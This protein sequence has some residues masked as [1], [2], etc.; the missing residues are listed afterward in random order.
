MTVI[1]PITIT[2][3][4]IAGNIATFMGNSTALNLTSSSLFFMPMAEKASRGLFDDSMKFNTDIIEKYPYIL[5]YFTYETTSDD[6]CLRTAI[7]SIRDLDKFVR[8]IFDSVDVMSRNALS[9][10]AIIG[11]LL[12]SGRLREMK[13]RS[14]AN[15]IRAYSGASYSYD[16][17]MYTIL[18]RAE[19][20]W[21]KHG[22]GYFVAKTKT[23][24]PV[25]DVAN[26][27]CDRDVVHFMNL[28]RMSEDDNRY[29]A[30]RLVLEHEKAPRDYMRG[31]RRFVEWYTYIPHDLICPPNLTSDEL[32]ELSGYYGS[33]E[34]YLNDVD[35]GGCDDDM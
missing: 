33:I 18:V 7:A 10:N 8:F 3:P 35:M 21:M 9:V 24:L 22:D 17:D 15:A 2:H 20:Y 29:H 34:D 23:Y 27:R 12:Q 14:M 13:D 32:A 11:G 31:V 6:H 5:A 28:I 1:T 30:L 19:V 26:L 16:T 25:M 4:D